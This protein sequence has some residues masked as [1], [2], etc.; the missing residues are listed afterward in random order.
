MTMSAVSTPAGSA[1]LGTGP[2]RPDG[3]GWVLGVAGLALLGALMGI[4]LVLGEVDAFFISLSVIACL[5][6][7]Y[8]FRVGTVLIIVMLP[9]EPTWLLPH[10]ILGV[11]GLNPINLVLGATLL[12]Y[13]LRGRLQRAGALMPRRLLWLYVLP[14]VAGGLLGAG[15]AEDIVPGLQDRLHFIDAGGYLRDMVV[16]PLLMVLAALLVGA[17]VA[18]SKKPERFLLPIGISIWLMCLLSLSVVARTSMSLADLAAP[19]ARTFFSGV[20]LHSNDLG[21]LYAVAYSLLLFAW[22]QSTDRRFRFACVATMAVVVTALVC[23]FSRGA[24]L[25]FLVVNALFLLWRFNAKTVALGLLV[26]VALAVVLPPEVFGR[27]SMGFGEDA[28]AV[29][30]GRIDGI[31]LPLLPEFFSSP[32]WGNGLGSVMWSNPMRQGLMLEVSHPHN[33]YLEAFLDVGLV[34]LG[35]LIAYFVHVWKGLRSLGSNAF[36]S[37]EMRGFYQ[38]AAAGLLSFFV[39]GFAGSSFAPRPEYVYLWLAIGMMYGQLARRPAG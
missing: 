15:H 20:G 6:V 30:A 17:A 34:G 33:A 19:G 9:A 27:V 32:I 21:R 2:V 8:D 10:S 37:P 12:S 23:T 25:G 39:T 38:G 16:K 5:V 26:A 1:R 14:L 35:L 24:F 11:T 22:A 28:N 31:W 13:L 7:L 3:L 29:S 18:R 36:L 4:G